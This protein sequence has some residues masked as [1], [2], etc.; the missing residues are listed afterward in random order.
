VRYHRGLRLG[1]EGLER[2]LERTAR[3]KAHAMSKAFTK[4]DADEPPLS[5]PTRAP[6]PA[7]TP[8]YVTPRGLALLRDE[9]DV[10]LRERAALAASD[11]PHTD[12]GRAP[13]ALRERVR[14][15]EERIASAMLVDPSR[16]VGDV[17]RFGARVTVR[18]E[19]DA[20]RRYAIVGVDEADASSGRVAFVAPLARAL[21]GKRV[22]ETVTVTTPRGEEEITIVAIGV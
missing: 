20:T 3:T 16:T 19:D 13:A 7:G 21:L 8:N 17:V 2:R 6:L 10:L 14:A 9:L 5:V 15:L 4:D 22:G 1:Y 18:G 11:A 12:A